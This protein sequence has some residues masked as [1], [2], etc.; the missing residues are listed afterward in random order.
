MSTILVVCAVTITIAFVAL[1]AQA[2]VTLAQVRNTAKAVEYVA[3]NADGK[4]SALDPIV[5]AVK[6]V[7][8]GV[9]SGWFRV[10]QAVYG[11]FSK[12]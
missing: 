1:A 8:N 2:I 5:E 12:K 10:A 3:L 11:L 4:L 6:T 9:S 7:S